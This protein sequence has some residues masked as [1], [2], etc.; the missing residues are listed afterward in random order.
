MDGEDPDFLDWLPGSTPFHVSSARTV[1]V[2][3]AAGGTE[4]PAALRAGAERV[5]AVELNPTLLRLQEEVLGRSRDPF[6]DPRVA[7]RV[8]DARAFVARTPERFDVVALAPLGGFG[9]AAAGVYGAGEDYLNTVEAYRAYLRTL[10]PEGTFV[11]SRW[12]RN[13]P[14]DLVKT[15]LTAAQALRAEGVEEVGTSLVLVRSWSVGTLM[16]KPSGFHAEEL[17]RIV[18]FAGGRM[19]DLDWPPPDG[20]PEGV[21]PAGPFNALEAPVFADAASAVAT[22]AEVARGFAEAYPFDVTPATDNRPYFGRFLR[23]SALPGLLSEERGSWLPFAEWGTLAVLA[24]L[25]AST[26]LAL[27]FT[28]LPGLWIVLR[29]RGSSQGPGEGGE[30]EPLLAGAAYF[31]AIGLAYLL[32]EIAAL[33]QLVLV[34]GHPVYA[35]SAVLGTFLVFSGV[36]S[37]VSER[38]PGTRAGWACLVAAMATLV[39][40]VVLTLAGAAMALPGA[41]RVLFVLLLLAPVATLMGFPFPLGIRLLGGRAGLP[42][43]WSVNGFAS[44]VAVALAAF[45]AMEVGSRWVLLLGAGFYLAAALVGLTASRPRASEPGNPLPERVG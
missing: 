34:L 12:I 29:R 22:G 7:V 44:V 33:Q 38:I 39:L 10:A 6:H 37:V 19:F 31:A 11:V 17:A 32:V 18:D 1:L 5:V 20:L 3:G 41:V 40:A 27:L 42:W 9:G 8:G 43:A 45:L 13:P 15:I 35:A 26:M 30:R 4:V 14:R 23:L 16:V 24:T 25:A 21:T 36:G 28:L 2:L